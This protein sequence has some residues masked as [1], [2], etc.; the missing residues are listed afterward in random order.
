[1]INKDVCRTSGDTDIYGIYHTCNITLCG[2]VYKERL[3]YV[4]RK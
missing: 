3:P 4:H 2:G 1:M